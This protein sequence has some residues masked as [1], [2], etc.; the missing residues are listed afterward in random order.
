MQ[1]APYPDVPADFGHWLA[2]LIDGEGCFLIVRDRRNW[3]RDYFTCHFRICLRSD[4]LA[5]LEECHRRTGIGT[6]HGA[7]NHASDFDR[8]PQVRWWVY[9]RSDSQRLVEILDVFRLRSKKARDYAIWREAVAAW[10]TVR[11]YKNPPSDNEPVWQCMGEL[12]EKIID[13]RRWREHP[14]V[15]EPFENDAV[16]TGADLTLL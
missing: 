15:L 11:Q 2:G 16:P 12:R 3:R 10:S 14:S 13:V 8:K 4:D 5:I 7:T 1:T 6:L 9:S